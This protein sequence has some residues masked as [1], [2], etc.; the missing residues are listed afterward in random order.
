[1]LVTR[2]VIEK[3]LCTK[4]DYTKTSPIEKITYD[5]TTSYRSY[6]NN[7]IVL[8]MNHVLT[9][10]YRKVFVRN[11]DLCNLKLGQLQV[12]PPKELHRRRR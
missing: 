6:N 9:C 10:H 11:L 12:P 2:L 5:C 3:L 1:M 7:N 8:S 4:I